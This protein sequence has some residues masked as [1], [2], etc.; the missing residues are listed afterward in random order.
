M[1]GEIN[2]KIP[3]ELKVSLLANGVNFDMDMF[4]EYKRD[5]Y[6]NQ[7]VYGRTSK[8][9][10]PEHKFPQVLLLG[11]GV[12]TA[13]L[14][15][16]SSPWNLK[17]DEESR[18]MLYH[19]NEFVQEVALP[20][21]PPFFGKHLSDGTPTESIIAVA[22]EQTP[23]FFIYPDCWFF[24]NGKPCKFCSLKS[25]RKTAGKNMVSSFS[26]QNI[27]EATRLFQNTK[28]RDI[29]LI[30]ITAGTA[31]T[32][33][34]TLEY[35]IKPIKAVHDAC[36]PKIPI[37]VLV[38]PPHNLDL[39]DEYKK[40]GVTSIA[41]NIEVYDRNIFKDICP[42][43]HLYYG[44]DK[45]FSAVERAVEVFGDYK[46]FC[47]LVWGLEPIESTMKAN[48]V[49]IDKGIGITS[50]IFHA[51]PGTGLAHRPHLDEESTLTLSKHT[52]KLF[53]EYPAARTI[54]E[55]SMRSTIDWE[56]KRGDFS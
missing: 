41:F 13:L 17:I 15:R 11:D 32:D 10:M 2:E 53:N 51:D 1:K 14:R 24:A 30:S 18:V 4:K 3:A 23:G 7:F 46:A 27:A 20:E 38:H 21:R 16:E 29:P 8:S 9:V 43:K 55:V 48:E 42:S 54:F 50:N 39:I 34:E 5:F 19:H 35:I 45:W 56:A 52:Q 49:M 12:V 6:D 22:G 26:E 37:H 36:D 28:W 40:A 25:T 44:Y 47:G 33:E 31:E